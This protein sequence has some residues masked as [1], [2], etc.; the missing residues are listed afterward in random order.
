MEPIVAL[1]NQIVGIVDPILNQYFWKITT[2]A[3]LSI[4]GAIPGIVLVSQVLLA[5]FGLPVFLGL[6]P[7]TGPLLAGSGGYFATLYL[8]MGDTINEIIAS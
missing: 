7:I 5:V 2:G 3:V 4:F 1:V 8:L 6:I